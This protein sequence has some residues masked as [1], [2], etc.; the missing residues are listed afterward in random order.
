MYS[1]IVHSKVRVAMTTAHTKAVRP[2]ALKRQSVPQSSFASILL[3]AICVHA[4]TRQ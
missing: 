3:I 4:C 1:T 2:N